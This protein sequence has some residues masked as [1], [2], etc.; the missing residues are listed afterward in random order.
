[1]NHVEKVF[2]VCNDTRECFA[3]KREFANDPY[4]C[5]ILTKVYKGDTCPFC[6]PECEVTNGVFY[7]YDPYGKYFDKKAK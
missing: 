6:K 1:M 2:P 7:P 5:Q 4:R 3:K